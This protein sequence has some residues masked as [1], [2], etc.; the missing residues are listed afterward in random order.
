[1]IALED[2]TV[3]IGDA[4][5]VD[6]AST[7]VRPGRL[8]A[9]VGPNGAGKTTLL[10]VAS[11]ERDPS[12][13]TVAMDGVPLGALAPAD[14]ARRRAVL[15]Q[16]SRLRFAFS[17][18]EVVVMGRTPHARGGESARDWRVAEAAL[19]SVGMAGLSDRSFP[20]LSGGEQ[21][22][23]HLARALAQVWDP[24]ATGH[25]YLLLD[26]P[27]ASLDLGHQQQVLRTARRLADDGASVL[28]ILHDL[29][30]A[31]Q[32][33]DRVVVMAGGRIR[34]QGPAGEVLTP[35]LIGEVFGWPVCVLQ[36]PTRACPLIVPD[37]RPGTSAPGSPPTPSVLASSS[38]PNPS[39]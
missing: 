19:R 12:S 32:F 39:T 18:L 25:R 15:P 8:T 20:T 24:P 10:Q 3:R 23:V 17:V 4:V 29:N 34:A 38:P 7:A 22:R 1:M 5:L 33:A 28:A 13:G 36:H 21:Q 30:L 14:Q 26:E 27:T 6:R 37:E 16:Q 2:V 31:A 9:V 35:G 11:G